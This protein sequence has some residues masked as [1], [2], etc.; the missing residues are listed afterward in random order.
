MCTAIPLCASGLPE[1]ARVA[2]PSR[3]SVGFEGT[4]NGS[5]RMRLGCA[6]ESSNGPEASAGCDIF[7]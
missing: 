4:G 3:K 5:Q 1:P 6:P 2:R 7:L